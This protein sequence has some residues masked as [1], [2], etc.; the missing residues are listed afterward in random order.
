MLSQSLETGT[1]LWS[2]ACPWD[3]VLGCGISPEEPAGTEAKL[4]AIFLLLCWAGMRASLARRLSEIPALHSTINPTQ[5][6]QP[7]T[8]PPAILPARTV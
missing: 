1:L 6:H 3:V 8:G 2:R 7:L 5:D 4:S